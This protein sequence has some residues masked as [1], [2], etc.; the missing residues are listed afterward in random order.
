MNR[1]LRSNPIAGFI[2]S[3]TFTE[4][5]QK[6]STHQNLF[7]GAVKE[8][9]EIDPLQNM[10]QRKS[11]IFGSEV[12]LPSFRQKNSQ[13]VKRDEK[14]ENEFANSAFVKH[15]KGDLHIVIKKDGDEDQDSVSLASSGLNSSESSSDNDVS[16]PKFIIS[17]DNKVKLSWD[18]YICVILLF[19]C[20]VNPV[21][22][23]FDF[24][25]GS[26]MSKIAVLID[27]SFAIDIITTFRSAYRDD[28][29]KLVQDP[30]KLALNY[31]FGWLFIDI[32]AIINFEWFIKGNA[33]N[34]N[35]ANF[36][37]LARALKIGKLAK[38]I[39]MTRLVRFLKIFK[40]RNKLLKYLHN[41]LKIDAA[42]E[43]LFFF[44]MI[45]FIFG[46]ILSC[47]WLLIAFYHYER[48]D[49]EWLKDN[50]ITEKALEDLSET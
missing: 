11:S 15:N 3:K 28:D 9:I 32:L 16:S 49:D 20:S 4:G 42:L 23:A 19:E 33:D 8:K 44:I 29:Y 6:S 50:W 27:I 13:Q 31:I 21:I 7:A 26:T 30:K 24:E 41:I 40:E 1:S 36:N 46:H 18:L 14:Q 35:T 48:D 38:I 37:S 10:I 2:D 12:L 22:I 39:R 25:L 17:P 5:K 34:S 43:R 45:F 47:L